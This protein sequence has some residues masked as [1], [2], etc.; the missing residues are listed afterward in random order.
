M[1]TLVDLGIVA[2][3]PDSA[4]WEAAIAAA[5]WDAGFLQQWQRAAACADKDELGLHRS[6]LAAFEIVNLDAPA[7]MFLADEISDTVP[8]MY[9]A[10]WLADEM[11]NEMVGE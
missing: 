7:S 5:L 2:A 11:M 8:V 6:L 4:N 3:E 10:A 1:V 9:L